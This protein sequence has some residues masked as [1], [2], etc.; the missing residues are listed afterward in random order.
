VATPTPDAEQPK[1]RGGWP[2]PRKA[3]WAFKPDPPAVTAVTRYMDAHGLKREQRGDLTKALNAMLAT[4]PDAAPPLVDLPEDFLD[5]GPRPKGQ[6]GWRCRYC[7][8]GRIFLGTVREE[9]AEARVPMRR[10]AP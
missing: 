8:K 5:H 4:H 2:G 6:V 7:G 10:S 9:A 3:A 1:R